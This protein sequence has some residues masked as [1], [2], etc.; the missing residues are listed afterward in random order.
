MQVRKYRT[1]VGR[2]PYLISKVTTQRRVGSGEA[3]S[4]PP[5]PPMSIKSR[6]VGSIAISWLASHATALFLRTIYRQLHVKC[7]RRVYLQPTAHYRHVTA[8]SPA[9]TSCLLHEISV[10]GSKALAAS[11]HRLQNIGTRPPSKTDRPRS[12]Y[13]LKKKCLTS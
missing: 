6:R 12:T 11:V 8:V 9:C 5:Q 4:S 13:S 3:A 7:V 1:R 10:R 2:W